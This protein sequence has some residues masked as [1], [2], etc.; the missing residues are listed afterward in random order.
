MK[1]IKNQRIRGFTL[2]E[3]LVVI[4][5]I[6]I[7]SGLTT[8]GVG[9]VRRQVAKAVTKARFSEY[10]AALDL[11]KIDNGYYPAFG[12]QPD[13]DG[14]LTFP[15][16]GTSDADWTDF[17]RTLYAMKSP[18]ESGGDSEKLDSKDAKALG[19]PKRKQHLKPSDENH[20]KE[21][22]GDLDWS[23]IKGLYKE[24]K[25]DKANVYLV[26]DLD[27]DGKFKNPDPKS[28]NKYEYVN[29]SVGFYSLE[30]KNGSEGKLLFKTWED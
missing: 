19:N 25:K 14:D 22:G 5:I 23:T 28:Q 15:P 3:L 8:G 13:S 10:I 26:I 6:V 16:Q 30:V 9:V 17:W 12:E 2:I 4:A 7:L 29:K 21:S 24:R 1:A 18:D 20:F 11:L 27:D